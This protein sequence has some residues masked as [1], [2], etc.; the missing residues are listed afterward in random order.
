MT[1]RTGFRIFDGILIAAALAAAVLLGIQVYSKTDTEPVLIIESPE[2]Q[3]MYRMDTTI[4]IDIPGPLGMTHVHL[5]GG[6]A[7]IS[8]SPCPNRTCIAAPPIS[9][10]GSWTACLPNRVLIRIDG[11]APDEMDAVGY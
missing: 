3:W 2:G 9:R 5:E 1:N 11:E 10:P 4:D 6:A 7:Y 8:E